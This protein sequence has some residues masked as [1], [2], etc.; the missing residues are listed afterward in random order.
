[1]NKTEYSYENDRDPSPACR[2]CEFATLLTDE[3]LFVLCRRLTQEISASGIC[4]EYVYDLLKRTP[5]VY[6]R[7]A[8]SL[9]H[10]EPIDF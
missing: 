10:F 8:L 3:S 7:P 5:A 1:M 4:D 6:L 9:P 2:Y